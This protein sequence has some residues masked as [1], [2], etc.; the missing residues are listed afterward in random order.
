MAARR[1][2]RLANADGD[3]K[4]PLQRSVRRRSNVRPGT[5]VD[6]EFDC[7]PNERFS[8]TNDQ[9]LMLGGLCPMHSA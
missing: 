2:D 5:Q 3:A 9:L 6:N 1:L 7:W 4:A 8:L